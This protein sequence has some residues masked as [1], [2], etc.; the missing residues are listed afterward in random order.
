LNNKKD[1]MKIYKQDYIYSYDDALKLRKNKI[2]EFTKKELE[3]MKTERFADWAYIN[4]Q[5]YF[6]KKFLD[7]IIQV[8]TELDNRIIDN[9]KTNKAGDVL[10][11]TIDEITHNGDKKYYFRL[12]TG[13]KI[14]KEHAKIGEIIKVHIPILRTAK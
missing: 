9:V 1:K 11:K 8:N 4:G 14:K 7:N 5:V 10:D 13:I 6:H 2:K 12:K 3:N